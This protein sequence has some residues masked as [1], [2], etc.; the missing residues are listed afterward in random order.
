MDLGLGAVAQGVTTSGLA[1]AAHETTVAVADGVLELARTCD[2]LL[3]VVGNITGVPVAQ[4]TCVGQ[5]TSALIV[6]I[7]AEGTVGARIVFLTCS[8]AVVGIGPVV[9]VNVVAELGCK[10]AQINDLL[11]GERV[12]V[13]EVGGTAGCVVRKSRRWCKGRRV[14]RWRAWSWDGGRYRGSGRGN[15]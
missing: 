15:R 14:P 7:R 8:T 3:L 1:I 10:R 5:L 12:L 4:D 2:P 13:D 11:T 9:V 6:K